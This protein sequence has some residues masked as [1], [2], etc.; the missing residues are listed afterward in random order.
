[1]IS[2]ILPINRDDGYF[3]QAVESILCQT[4]SDFEFLI[5]A[6]N[7][8]D[9][10]WAKIE[11]IQK[12]DIRIKSYRLELGGLTF[13]LNYGLNIARGE[14]IARMD[15]DDISLVDR[16]KKQ[17]EFLD[18][19]NSVHILGTQIK[20]ID[21]KGGVS[22]FK[23]SVLPENPAKK[24]AYYKCPLYH[25]TVMFRKNS[26]L[27]IGGYKYGFYGEDYELWLRCIK[28]NLKIVN[29]PDILLNYRI[30]GKQLSNTSA[31]KNI[32]LSAMLYTFFRNYKDLGF[33]KGMLVQ[34][35][36]IQFLIL[37]THKIR[38]KSKG[39]DCE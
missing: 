29:L 26:I 9:Q 28:N 23:A 5:I 38:K 31:E 37:I 27:A 34:N 22:V 32:Y 21:E 20:Y 33:L 14:Y 35:K 12:K 16:F 30:H 17:V 10:L 1:M 15:A 4:Y 18:A 11:E 7:C 3:E 8:D 13:A 39:G 19:N 2:V 25:P 6:N 24:I 36:I